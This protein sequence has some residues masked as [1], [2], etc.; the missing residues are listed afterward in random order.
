MKTNPKPDRNRYLSITQYAELCGVRPATIYARLEAGTLKAVT[1]ILLNEDP[2]ER[3]ID[4]QEYPPVKELKTGRRP[5][6]EG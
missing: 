2:G 4:V 6:R 1:Q 3:F 5:K